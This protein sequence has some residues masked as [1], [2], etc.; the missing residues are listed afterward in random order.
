MERR[1]FFKSAALAGMA[2][3]LTVR[4]SGVPGVLR[5][6]LFS[7]D[8]KVNVSGGLDAGYPLPGKVRQASASACSR[9]S[10]LFSDES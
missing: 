5:V 9:C 6:T 4:E 2:A 10:A 8:G 1:A 3:P 7:D